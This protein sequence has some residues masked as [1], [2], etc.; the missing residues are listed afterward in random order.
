MLNAIMQSMRGTSARARSNTL[1]SQN[2]LMTSNIWYC[3]KRNIIG[4]KHNAKDFQTGH[5][6]YACNTRREITSQGAAK[7]SRS[8]QHHHF[9]LAAAAA[10]A[11]AH[12]WCPNTA[13]HIGN[14]QRSTPACH[15][16]CTKSNA[17]GVCRLSC[18]CSR[19]TPLV[20]RAASHRQ[21]AHSARPLRVGRAARH[22]QLSNAL[23]QMLDDALQ[24]WS[25]GAV[26]GTDL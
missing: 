13:I 6:W 18:A 22:T 19:L 16:Q 12:R 25:R 11:K 9:Q 24:Q 5:A 23:Q 1:K 10:P 20:A 8:H 2:G 14:H 3:L 15:G 4:S 17:S 7:N 26:R 21:V